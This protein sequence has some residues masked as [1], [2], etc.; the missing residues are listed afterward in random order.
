MQLSG[1]NKCLQCAKATVQS[2]GISAL[3][4]SLPITLMMNAPYHI[5]AVII[6]ENMKKVVKPK[7]RDW[8]FASYFLCAAFAGA[9]SSLITCPMDNIK[10]KLQTQSTISSCEAF[11]TKNTA[12]LVE[13][14]YKIKNKGGGDSKISPEEIKCKVNPAEIEKVNNPINS[15]FTKNKHFK[16]EKVKYQNIRDTFFKIYREDGIKKGFFRGV[17]P[18]MFCN[19]PSCAISWC[20][21]EVMKHLLSDVLK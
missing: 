10:T 2:E 4:R 7:E 14:T 3:Y 12:K 20:S 21:Y 8:Q 15:N 17:V 11:E 6:N 19:S 1:Q 13:D 16:E 18:R 5:T 9:V